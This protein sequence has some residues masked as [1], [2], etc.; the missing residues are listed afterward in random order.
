MQLRNDNALGTIDNKGTVVGH[1]R[2]FAHVDF[3]LFNV[4]YG[5]FWRFALIDHQTQFH[6][7]RCRIGHATDLT[8]FHVKDRFT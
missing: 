2:N 7:Q 1:E 5:A 4:F 6:A 3:L 8:L